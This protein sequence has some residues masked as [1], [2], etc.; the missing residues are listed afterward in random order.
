MNTPA[1]PQAAEPVIP[2]EERWA[3]ALWLPCRVGVDIPISGLT[4][5]QLLK[6]RRHS[7]VETGQEESTNIPVQVN[8]Q[9]IGWGQFEVV[10]E[11]LAVHLVDMI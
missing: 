5:G 6:L 10:G 2:S 7:V 3:E 9:L 4:V 8:G 11:R 1:L